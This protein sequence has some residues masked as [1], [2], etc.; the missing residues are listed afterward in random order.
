MPSRPNRLE[1]DFIYYFYTSHTGKVSLGD[2][3]AG[4]SFTS[5]SESVMITVPTATCGTSNAS[6]SDQ[7]AATLACTTEMMK[8]SHKKNPVYERQNAVEIPLE[9]EYKERVEAK[10]SLESSVF[11][12]GEGGVL[13]ICRPNGRG[14][15]E[16]AVPGDKNKAP[17]PPKKRKMDPTG[18]ATSIP[19]ESV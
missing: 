8:K 18:S 13:T 3:R 12:E 2:F 16:Y 10:K 1:T 9:T 6:V 15:L 14:G 5:A 17:L 11:L 4:R 7:V 19:L